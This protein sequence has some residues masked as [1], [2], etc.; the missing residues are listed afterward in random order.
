[1]NLM[2]YPGDKTIYTIT[3][4]DGREIRDLHLNGN[5]FVS[6]EEITEEM[7]QDGLSHITISNDRGLIEEMDNVKFTQC[8]PIDGQ[9]YFVLTPYTNDELWKMQVESN[10]QYMAMMSDIEI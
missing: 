2:G 9:Y 6:D 3:L 10:M 5:N 1:M 7:V 8:L 4:S